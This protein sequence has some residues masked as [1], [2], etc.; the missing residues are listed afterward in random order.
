MVMEVT[1]TL[2]G[3]RPLEMAMDGVGL[4]FNSSWEFTFSHPKIDLYIIKMAIRQWLRVIEP[5]GENVLRTLAFHHATGYDPVSLLD[6]IIRDTCGMHTDDMCVYDIR[7]AILLDMLCDMVA[8]L[9]DRAGDNDCRKAW[10]NHGTM[11][12]EASV[13]ED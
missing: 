12:I 8:D 13:R 10:H 7:Q 3:G 4:A 6:T 9:V 11:F 1:L 5:D 2:R